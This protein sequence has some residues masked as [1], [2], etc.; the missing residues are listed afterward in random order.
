MLKT[1]N[2]T[3]VVQLSH[4][5]VISSK[6]LKRKLTYHDSGKIKFVYFADDLDDLAASYLLQFVIHV[7]IIKIDN[8]II[9]SFSVMFVCACTFQ[10]PRPF[11]YSIPW[12]VN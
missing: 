1:F 3:R 11:L 12:L 9:K 8:E 4:H 2:L 10:F 5:R 7:R 6:G